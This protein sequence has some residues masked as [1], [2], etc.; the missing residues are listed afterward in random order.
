M[1]TSWRDPQREAFW[2]DV[3]RRKSRSRLSVAEFCRREGLLKSNRGAV[4]NLPR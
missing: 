4:Q 2:R 1:A 3:L